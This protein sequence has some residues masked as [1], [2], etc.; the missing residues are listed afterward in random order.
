MRRLADDGHGA[1]LDWPALRHGMRCARENKK[2]NIAIVSASV[3]SRRERHDEPG[4]V[5]V[6]VWLYAHSLGPAAA[7]VAVCWPYAR[8]GF[9]EA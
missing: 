7:K 2:D 4:L 9:G 8:T 6:S 3:R 1:G 5:S